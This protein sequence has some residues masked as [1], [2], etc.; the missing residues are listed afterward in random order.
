MKPLLRRFANVLA[1]G[2]LLMVLM[3]LIAVSLLRWQ[4]PLPFAPGGVFNT[5]RDGA[6]HL[7]EQLQSWGYAVRP[8]TADSPWPRREDDLILML[9]PVESF[10]NQELLRLDQWVRGGGTLL[11]ALTP[12]TPANLRNN[13]KIDVRPLWGRQAEATLLLPTLNWPPVGTVALRS[14][15]RLALDCGQAAIHLGN[16]ERPFLASFGYG[17]G[18]VFVLAG[19]HPFTN[20][21]LPEAGNAQL[22]RNLVQLAGRPGAQ[23]AF[24]EA[25]R[26]PQG[27][28]LLRTTTGWALLLSL[29][30]MLPALF[31]L[32]QPFGKPQ[33]E[34]TAVPPPR[35]ASAAFIQQLAQAQKSM[36]DGQRI[37]GHYWDRLKRRLA[38]RY[39]LDP[40]LPDET[41]LAA[42]RPYQDEHAIGK[43]IHLMVAMDHP[44]EDGA[45]QHW[46]SE[47]IGFDAQAEQIDPLR[48]GPVSRGMQ[49]RL[50]RTTR[51]Q[52]TR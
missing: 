31:W 33:P 17:E 14:R 5:R 35:Q 7:S 32:N 16:C 23:I 29:L 37:R 4:N 18:A 19:L 28:W 1:L 3:G 39:A 47:V 46:V 8:I 45:L 36:D 11:L 24:D 48:R 9:A 10:D 21:G 44:M 40:G 26:Q 50:Q 42:L 49:R 22:L 41:F 15:L 52:E 20:G 13:F 34:T 51:P 30:L 25:H 43:L 6:S 2:L 38:R 27:P 12:D